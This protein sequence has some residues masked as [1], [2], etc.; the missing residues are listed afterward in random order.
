MVCLLQQERGHNELKRW[1]QHH[2]WKINLEK[3]TKRLS[4][5]HTSVPVLPQAILVML[6]RRWSTWKQRFSNYLQRIFLFQLIKN[7]E[8]NV[9]RWKL[10]AK[11][12]F[13]KIIIVLQNA[14]K[15]WMWF[16]W[17]KWTWDN[18]QIHSSKY[19]IWLLAM[20]VLDNM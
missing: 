10:H 6:L 17:T 7:L 15:K 4:I 13:I 20:I 19:S 2:T 5:K 9:L 1:V 18:M 3:S 16:I 14:L 12:K 8:K 11:K